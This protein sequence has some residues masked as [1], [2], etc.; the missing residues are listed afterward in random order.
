MSHAS[1]K[2]VGA[3]HASV[4]CSYSAVC[5]I[6]E[7]GS[8]HNIA[9][10]KGTRVTIEV[11]IEQKAPIKVGEAEEPKQVLDSPGHWPVNHQPSSL[12]WRFSAY[13]EGKH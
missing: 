5:L 2:V 1:E 12:V 3:L 6:D 11:A 9:P 4:A 10:Q 7:F 13:P 8:P